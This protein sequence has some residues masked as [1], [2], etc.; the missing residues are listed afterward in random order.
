MGIT[1]SRKVLCQPPKSEEGG[2]DTKRNLYAFFANH[3]LVR[4]ELREEVQC[5]VH[6]Q[7]EHV[8]N[9][10]PLIQES[11]QGLQQEDVRP[12]LPMQADQI[13]GSGYDSGP[14][15]LLRVGLV[16]RDYP[17]PRGKP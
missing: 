4:D 10:I 1:P 5:S 3:R 16:R 13:Q 2:R 11:P 6:D 14:T 9:S 15:E 8:R 17:I 7:Q 12:L